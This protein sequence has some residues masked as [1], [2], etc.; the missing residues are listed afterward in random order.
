MV[1]GG[2][3]RR[4][5]RKLRYSDDESDLSGWTTDDSNAAKTQPTQQKPT[6][7]TS[8]F[9]SDSSEGNSDKCSIC[10]LRFKDQE[11]G[12]PENCD[13]IFCVDCISEWAKN[14]NTCPVDRITF[15]SIIVKT[16][17]GGSVI[18][19]DP[20]IVLPRRPSSDIFIVEDTTYCEVSIII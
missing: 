11:V 17:A 10:L 6:G 16:H 19:S 3:R 14:V 15:N 9:A 8:G 7:Q 1:V 5:L 18:R 4:E 13:H 2:V 20:V 12:T